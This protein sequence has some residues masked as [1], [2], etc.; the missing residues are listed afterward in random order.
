[1]VEAANGYAP[2]VVA[3][4]LYEIAQKF[5]SFYADTP[6]LN[7]SEEIRTFREGLVKCLS[8]VMKNGL[9]LLGIEVVEK[10]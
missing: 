5:N 1:M 8:L 10:M 9:K 7:A 2:Q 3:N 4:Y 6:V